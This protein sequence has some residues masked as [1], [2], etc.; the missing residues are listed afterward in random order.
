MA[1][2]A[3]GETQLIDAQWAQFI[4]EVQ[5]RSHGEAMQINVAYKCGDLFRTCV[6]V[7]RVE[8]QTHPV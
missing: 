1:Y 5:S 6:H 4:F 2:P 3:P 8:L 7:T